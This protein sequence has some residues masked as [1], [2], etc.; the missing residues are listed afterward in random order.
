MALPAVWQA[1]GKASAGRLGLT[2]VFL[3][4]FSHTRQ[5][6]VLRPAFEAAAVIYKMPDDFNDDSIQKKFK[7]DPIYAALIE[8]ET[9]VL[10]RAAEEPDEGKARAL[11]RRALA[12]IDAR[13]KRWFAGRDAKLKA[14]DDHFPDHGRVRPMEGLCVAVV[15]E[16]WRH[17]AG[18]GASEDARKPRM[19]VAGGRSGAVPGDRPLR[20]GW[21]SQAFGNAA[22]RLRH[23]SA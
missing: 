14:Y 11:P 2:G 13:Q 3:H 4:E 9:D 12:L 23:R 16:R 7:S 8:K 19:V 6:N 10:Y 20:A 15:H 22:G 18:G 5:M 21:A 1:G 17:D